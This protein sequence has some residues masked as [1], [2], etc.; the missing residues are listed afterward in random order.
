MQTVLVGQANVVVLPVVA[1]ATGGPITLGTVNFYL[2][3][4]DGTNAGKWYRGSDTSWQA[5]ESV[6]GVATHKADGH[7]RLSLPSAV[8]EQ[9]VNYTLYAKESGDLHIPVDRPILAKT[10]DLDRVLKAWCAGKWQL[11]SG[12]TDVYELLDAD[13]GVTVILEMTLSQTTPYRMIAVQI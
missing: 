2:V 9:N 12:E 10:E 3:D 5:A 8:W 6:A 11:K 4:E 7:W 1:K 13:D